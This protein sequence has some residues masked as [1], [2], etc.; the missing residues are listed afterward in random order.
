M[1]EDEAAAH[2]RRNEIVRCVGVHHDSQ[3]EI[4]HDEGADAERSEAHGCRDRA[5]ARDA[6]HRIEFE[7][8]GTVPD[9]DSHAAA[10]RDEA[11][12]LV[13]RDRRTTLAEANQHIGLAADAD[14]GLRIPR[15]A[16]QPALPG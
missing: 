12:D 1:T 14:A 7:C 4:N 10:A 2:P 5:Q 3:P 6:A 15:A 8:L 16:K 11:D 13:S 9:V